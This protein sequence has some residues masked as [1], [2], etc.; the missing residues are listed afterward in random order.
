[1]IVLNPVETAIFYEVFFQVFCSFISPQYFHFFIQKSR[2]KTNPPICAHRAT[3]Q[4][5]HIVAR[6]PIHWVNCIAIHHQRK[7]FAGT[8][9]ALIV[10]VL[11][12]LIFAFGNIQE[13]HISYKVHPT[14]M[15]EHISKKRVPLISSHDFSRNWSVCIVECF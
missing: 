2:Q 4:E 9:V 5:A 12:S 7:S 3:H 11:I 13:K 14:S 10:C 15:K 6:S 8:N 1:M